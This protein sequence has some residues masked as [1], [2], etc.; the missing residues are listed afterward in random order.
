M[1]KTYIQKFLII[2]WNKTMSSH[3][4]KEVEEKG[5]AQCEPECL[6]H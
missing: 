1:V 5:S 3:I 6:S 4:N 2:Q